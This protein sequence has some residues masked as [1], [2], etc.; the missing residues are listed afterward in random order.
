MKTLSSFLL[1]LF[2]LYALTCKKEPPVVPPPPSGPDTTSHNFAWDQYA[3]GGQ[4]GSSYFRDAA[5]INDAD[6]WAVGE[7][8][9]NDS[10]G[11]PDPILYN[12]IHW[13]GATWTL[14]RLKYFPPGAI[15][16]SAIGAGSS[17]FARSENDIW[18]VAGYIY[19]YNGSKFTPFY[20]TG[21][22]GA[23]K[24]WGDAAGN[25]WSVGNGG[26]IA[27]YSSGAWT[28]LASGTSLDLEDIWGAMNPTTGE[29]EIL[30]VAA[31]NSYPQEGH[32][33]L[34]IQGGKVDSVSTNPIE[35]LPGFFSVWFVPNKH[36]YIVG[37][38]IYQNDSISNNKW[39]SDSLHIT[40]YGTT[41]V[42]GNGL[43]D[44]FVVGAFGE[45]LHWNGSSW[46]SFIN[47]TGLSNGSYSSV[48]ASGNL[49]VAV[50]ENYATGALDSK[51]IITIGKRY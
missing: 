40:K 16:D 37:D 4:G 48:A 1:I 26:I 23:N 3:F 39:K 20:N 12:V 7:I 46:K 38:G 9:A 11:K 32:I 22:E 42:R 47:Q 2:C 14:M 15:G 41:C 29:D 33:L 36:Y 21:G 8:Y 17:I 31:H 13:N 5:I 30:A 49:V 43:N 18:L 44:V 34:S 10:T 27:H 28:K 25:L 24:I 51:G 19:H 45:F 6:I 50:G 35:Y